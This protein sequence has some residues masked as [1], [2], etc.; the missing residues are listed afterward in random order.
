VNA[1]DRRRTPLGHPLS[2][3]VVFVPRTLCRECRTASRAAQCD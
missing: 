3:R 1:E 2:V